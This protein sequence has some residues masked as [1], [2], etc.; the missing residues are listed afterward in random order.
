LLLEI[1]R[2]HPEVRKNPAPSVL[3]RSFGDHSLNLE[4][5]AFVG[6]VEKTLGITSDLCFS[7]FEA[8]HKAGIQIPF[9][10]RDLRVTLDEAQLARLLDRGR[11]DENRPLDR[12]DAPESRGG[13]A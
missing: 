2:G 7:V 13:A 9:P 11:S 8:F 1:A 12:Q 6:D 5:I 10:Q 4:L 3:F